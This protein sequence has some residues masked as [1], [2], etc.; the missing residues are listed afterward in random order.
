MIS[1]QV[2][3]PD[4]IHIIVKQKFSDV[5]LMYTCELQCTL[6]RW[7]FSV[8]LDMV[9]N[10]PLNKQKSTSSVLEFCTIDTMPLFDVLYSSGYI[11]EVDD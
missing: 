8:T 4:W 10:L 1:D 5:L 2:Q 7:T 6:G 9:L 3:V 11:A